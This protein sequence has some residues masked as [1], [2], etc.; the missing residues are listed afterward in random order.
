MTDESTSTW[1]ML[2][3]WYRTAD[4]WAGWHAG[5]A[6]RPQRPFSPDPHEYSQDYAAGCAQKIIDDINRRSN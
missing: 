6:G 5:A 2:F 3:M 4:W 1:P